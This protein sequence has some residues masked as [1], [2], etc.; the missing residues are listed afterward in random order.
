MNLLVECNARLLSYWCPDPDGTFDWF[1][2]YQ[3]VVSPCRGGSFEKM[4]WL[5]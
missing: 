1:D 3:V 2:S 4:K 5:Q